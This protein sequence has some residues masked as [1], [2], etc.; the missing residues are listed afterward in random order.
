MDRDGRSPEDI[1]NLIAAQL[2]EREK[3]KRADM[4]VDNSGDSGRIK[5]FG[6]MLAALP[7]KPDELELF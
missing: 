7:D 1:D 4:V 5:E 2:P 3:A 6:R